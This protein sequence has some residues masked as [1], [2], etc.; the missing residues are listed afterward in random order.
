MADTSLMALALE[1]YQHLLPELKQKANTKASSGEAEPWNMTPL[2]RLPTVGQVLYSIKPVP[3]QSILI[4]ACEDGLPFLLD[5]AQP[6]SGPVLV[7]GD[8]RCGKTR[9]LKVMVES[10]LRLASPREIQ[11]GVVTAHPEEWADLFDP[12]QGVKHSLGI[13][14][15]NHD[16]LSSLINSLAGLVEDRFTGR[17]NGPMVLLIIE[18]LSQVETLE[19]SDQMTFHWLLENGA[20]VGVWPVASALAG[21]ATSLPYW[22]DVFR[23]RLFGRI[24]SPEVARQL[25]IYPD[26]EAGQLMAGSE[27][28]TRLDNA[29]MSYWVPESGD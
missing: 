13:Y 28:C 2:M 27:F 29:W 24:A 21:Q 15:W 16:S 18:D 10:A 3:Y 12:Y 11:I 20:Q 7:T 5:L 23:T 22:V 14:P 9:Q 8:A 4:G 17:R 25:A 26:L 1:A 6:A 19:T